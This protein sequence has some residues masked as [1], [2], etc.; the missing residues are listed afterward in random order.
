MVDIGIMDLKKV[1]WVSNWVLHLGSDSPRLKN[2]QNNYFI[3][4]PGSVQI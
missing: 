3:F 1:N 2:S 4:T